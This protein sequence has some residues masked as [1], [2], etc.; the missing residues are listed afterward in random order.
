MEIAARFEHKYLLTIAQRDDLLASFAGQLLPDTGGGLSGRYPVVSLYCDSPD[1]KCRWEAWRGVPS[2]RKLRMRIYGTKDGAIAPAIFLEIKHKDGNEGA[3]RRAQLSA[4]EAW[5]AVNGQH[6]S[7][8]D[9]GEAR[10][11]AEVR[12]LVAAEAFAPVC[13]IRYDRHAYR[14]IDAHDIELL[15]ITFDHGIRARF[16]QLTPTPEDDNCPLTVLADNLCLMEV[17]GST[18]V[19]YAF[20]AHLSAR[21][22]YPRHFSKY[23]ECMRLHGATPALSCLS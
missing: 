18:A 7:L 14:F 2:R 20:A 16:D 12:Q 8:P 4:S 11:L 17:K 1:Q 10:V 22:L 5:A 6:L 21:G 19:P 13:V 23:S 3:K 9:A 15:R